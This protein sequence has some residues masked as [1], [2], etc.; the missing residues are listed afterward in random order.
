M[1]FWAQGFHTTAKNTN[2]HQNKLKTILALKQVEK[3]QLMDCDAYWVGT[4]SSHFRSLV[5]YPPPNVGVGQGMWAQ[6]GWKSSLF[7]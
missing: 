4:I 6:N 7:C 5:V 3:A 2:N 1:A